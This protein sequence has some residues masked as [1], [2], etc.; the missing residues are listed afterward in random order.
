MN[1]FELLIVSLLALCILLLIIVIVLLNRRSIKMDLKQQQMESIQLFNKQHNDLLDRLDSRLDSS[2]DQTISQLSQLKTS[3]YEQKDLL[4]KSS[5]DLLT[6]I[7]EVNHKSFVELSEQ[8]SIRLNAIDQKVM[9]N[10]EEGFKKSNTTFNQV[11]ERLVKI[12]EAQSRIDELSDDIGS[13]Q[14]VL[15][16]KQSRGL[17]GEIQLNNILES[18]FGEPDNKTYQLQFTFRNNKRVDAVV[19]APEPLGTLAI[20]SK[21]P[22]DNYRR[23]SDLESDMTL[24]NEASK[25]FVIDVK[26]HIDDIA[27]K[28]IIRNET[29]NQAL[30]FIPAEAI[31]SYIHAYQ[32]EIVSYANSK[33]VW[34]VSPTTLMATLTTIQTILRNIERNKYTH[35]IHRHLNALQIEFERYHKRW[36]ELSRHFELLNK[37][38]KDIHVTSQKIT[39]TFHK[40]NTVEIDSDQLDKKS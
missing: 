34:L 25:Q 19:F 35:E 22:L 10:L 12:N 3:L 33:R 6:L 28:Y 13:L 29:S 5:H 31:Y 38:V 40:I 9:F 15:T 20:D 37:D 30:M 27:N 1:S 39:N 2:Y 11:L 16:N 36:N 14:A 8:L 23:L 18:I 17:F 4:N 24:R 32:S 7:N 21:F 26:K